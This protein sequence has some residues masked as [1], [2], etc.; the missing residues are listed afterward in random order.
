LSIRRSF[1]VVTFV[2]L[3]TSFAIPSQTEPASIPKTLG[4]TVR[5]ASSIRAGTTKTVSVPLPWRANMV[6]VSFVAPAHQKGVTVEAR[7]HDGN[8]WSGWEN[9]D[10]NDNGGDGIEHEY[11]SARTSTS[12][13][14][15]GTADGL[16][17][18]ITVPENARSLRDV[19]VHLINTLGNA[20]PKSTVSRLLAAVGGFFRLQG[21]VR[22]ADAAPTQPTIISRAQWGADPSLLNLPC[23]GIADRV[24]MVIVHHTDTGNSY[25]RSTSAAMVRGIYRYHT[26]TRGYCDIAYNFLVDKYGQIFEGRNGGITKNVIGA[27]ALGMNTETVGVATLGT[28][29]STSPTQ[30]MYTSLEKLLAW[31]MDLAHIPPIGKV[32]MTYRADEKYHNGQQIS[33]NRISGHRDVNLTSCPGSK[34]YSHLSGIR[35]AVNKLGLPKIYLPTQSTWVVRRDG[36][37]V[38]ESSHLTARFTQT[39]SWAVKLSNS[40]GTVVRTLTGTSSSLS[41]YITGLTASSVPLPTGRY[42]WT[43]TA[44]NSSGHSATPASGYLYIISSHPN[45]TLLKDTTGRYLVQGGAARAVGSTEYASYASVFG[46]FPVIGTGSGERARYASGAAATLREGTLLVDQ[47]GHHYIWSDG[48]L[49]Q[50]QVQG[51]KDAFEALGYSSTAALSVADTYIASLPQGT[52]VGANDLGHPDGTLLKLKDPSGASTYY[53]VTNNQTQVRPATLLSVKSW[54]RTGESVLPSATELL[55][56][57]SPGPAFVPRDGTFIKATDGGAPWLVSDGVKRRFYSGT[58]ASFMGYA[59]STLRTATTAELNA[60]PTGARIG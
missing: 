42:T 7:S 24:Q 31:R 16:D 51:N 35:D 19:R 30:A 47:Q 57:A 1:V 56:I 33:L 22:P 40:S 46:S 11:Q 26:N 4:A 59:S 45:G 60:I 6:G 5:L 54:Y 55:L 25:S 3:A 13:M 34:L 18:R 49:R 38:N 52:P 36:D 37:G 12:A 53:V 8:G 10:E 29:T 15:I 21:N 20:T 50:F 2:V 9:I 14:W 39:L 43:L 48:A 27:H 28:F 41:T 58:L 23:P 17:V 32:T 44:R